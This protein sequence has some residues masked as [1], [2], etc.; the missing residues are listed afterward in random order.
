VTEV[1]TQV[2]IDGGLT[3]A[4]A[5]IVGRALAHAKGFGEAIKEVLEV[6]VGEGG[7][8]LPV[9]E[10]YDALDNLIRQLREAMELIAAKLPSQIH[11]IPLDQLAELQGVR[12]V[13]DPDEVGALWPLDDDPD[14]MLAHILEERSMRRQGGRAP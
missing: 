12:P 13:Q 3:E 11:S 9:T 6:V 2:N 1:T 10:Y 8:P 5:K 14:R 4:E 7:L